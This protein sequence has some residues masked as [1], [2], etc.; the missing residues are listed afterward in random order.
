MFQYNGR[1]L[2][3]EIVFILIAL[4][5]W[6]PFYILGVN[7]L[8]PATSVGGTG[9]AVPDDPGFESYA[10]AWEGNGNGTLGAA[11]LNSIVIA[12]GS[13][14]CLLVIGSLAAYVL[15][16][17]PGKLSGALYALFVLGIILPYQLGVVPLY[18]AF[19]GLGLVGNYAGM[20]LLYTGLLMPFSVFLYTG[21]I[22]ALPRDY[23]EAASVDGAGHLRTFVQ[24][25]FPLLRPIT[26][27][28]AILTGLIV[29]NDFFTQLVFVGGSANETLP[30]AVYSA[31]GAYATQWS[32]VFA[33]V[34]IAV[35]PVL[36]AYFFSQRHLIRGF[37]G[38]TKG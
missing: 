27:T 37:T 34:V 19:R 4:L 6:L 9:L 18:A 2:I 30:V 28:V 31:V 11:L 5:W 38:G 20:I 8:A 26:A 16:R 24:V 21:F 32:V 35:I 14:I 15:S 17:R 23:E 13:V 3:R 22:R 7:S 10:Q 33:A 1:S 12:G 36:F 29:W 25:V